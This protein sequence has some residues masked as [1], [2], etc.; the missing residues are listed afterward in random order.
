M[1][2]IKKEILKRL[3][4]IKDKNDELLNTF[5]TNKAFK[6]KKIPKAKYWRIIQGIIL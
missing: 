1:K 4:I 2:K 3:E 6:N 5:A